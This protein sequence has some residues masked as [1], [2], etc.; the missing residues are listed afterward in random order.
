[1]ILDKRKLLAAGVLVDVT[2]MS[3]SLGILHPM[4]V[5]RFVWDGLIEPEPRYHDVAN[6][7]LL[8]ILECFYAK[9]KLPNQGN[10]LVMSFE[11]VISDPS[12]A[13][14]RC[15]VPMI[16]ACEW[17]VEGKMWVIIYHEVEW[18]TGAGRCKN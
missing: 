15:P 6:E 18:D 14:G 3:R 1:M 13:T 7:R 16:A 4:T 10:K 11:A 5:T 17:D 8:A 9:L 2:D 12:G